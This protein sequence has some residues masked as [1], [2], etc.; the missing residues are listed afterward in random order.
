MRELVL[1]V[2]IAGGLGLTVFYPFAGVLLWAWFTCMDPHQEAY[3]IV[4]T[5][6]L[7]LVIACVTL[8]GLLVS[9]ERKRPPADATFYAVMAFLVW[10][11]FNTFFAVVPDV[12]WPIWNLTWKVFLLGLVIAMSATSK[13]RIHA[14]VWIV[15]ISLFYYGV[16]GGLFTLVTGGHAHVLGPSQSI[17]GDNNQLALALLMCLPLANYLRLH[18]EKKWVRFLLLAS[19]VIVFISILG[20]YSRGAYL[21]LLALAFV[22]WLRARNK[23]LYPILIV[24]VAVPALY[25]MPQSFYDRL[26][27]LET[28]DTDASFQ[29]RIKAWQVAYHYAAE[30]FPFG[31]GFYGPQ[32]PQVF[33]QY[34]PGQPTHAAHSIF[35]EVMGDN[36]FTG[37]AIYL[38]IL[39]LAFWNCSSIL[40]RARG[41]PEFAWAR[42]LAAMIQL[43]LF[44]FCVGGAALSMAYYDVFA[45][46]LGLLSALKQLIGQRMSHKEPE[47]TPAVPM[48]DVASE[49]ESIS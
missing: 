8:L 1:L 47:P 48:V 36:G 3:G 15:V 45:I 2:A 9:K 33:N 14:V 7:N 43:T 35:F 32:Q 27:T 42:D 4:A 26:Y 16:K 6:P 13:V 46:C 40:R 49:N 22:A 29:G 17:I 21:A 24:V 41:Q 19:M 10:S 18:S 37:F 25:F 44:V 28:T 39:G 11:T 20:S 34:F 5:L 23:L 38:V 31:A 30:H 12:S